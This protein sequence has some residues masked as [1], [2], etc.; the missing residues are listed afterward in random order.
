[1]NRKIREAHI[2]TV[3]CLSAAA[4]YKDDEPDLHATRTGHYARALALA[5]G[6]GAAAA[7]DLFLIAPLHDLGKIGI[8]D[9]ILRKPGSLTSSERVAMQRHTVIGAHII[10][11]HADGLLRMAST[12]ALSHHEKWDGTGYPQ[13]LSGHAIP[14]EARLVAVV[15]VFDALTNARPYKHAWPAEDA[16]AFIEGA[17]GT[18][19]DPELVAAFMDCV[20]QVLRLFSEF[21]QPDFQGVNRPRPC[22]THGESGTTRSDQNKR[23]AAL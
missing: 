6:D 11:E 19:F 13:G 9:A 16:I 8:S 15:D 5:A 10:G 3:K 20:P 2:Q 21:A 23:G 4:G 18:H 12:I 22:S 17:G 1:M 7:D 14:R